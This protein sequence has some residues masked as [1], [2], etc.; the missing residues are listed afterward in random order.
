MGQRAIGL[1]TRDPNSSNCLRPN[2]ESTMRV[3]VQA[4]G[5]NPVDWKMRSSGPLRLAARLVG[6]APQW[7]WGRF[8]GVADS[9]GSQGDASCPGIEWSGTPISR[10]DNAALC[11]H[12]PRPW[13]RLPGPDSVDIAISQ[14]HR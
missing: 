11:R 7:W 2:P 3:S 8:H 14:E 4:I 9:V 1:R 12:R 10:M 6:Q 13:T 5:V